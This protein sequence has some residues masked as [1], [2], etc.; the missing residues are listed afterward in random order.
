MR[1]NFRKFKSMLIALLIFSLIM[2]AWLGLADK[3]SAEYTD[4]AMFT[5][6]AAYASAR[7]INALISTFQ[8]AQ[9]S[10]GFA[11]I[12]V[13]E[14]LDPIN[15]LIERFSAVMMWCLGSLALQKLMI[16]AL[17]TKTF[18]VVFTLVG[19][20]VLLGLIFKNTTLDFAKKAFVML[21]AMRFGLFVVLLLNSVI[22]SV[23]LNARIE[24]DKQQ[25]RS[26]QS[27]LAIFESEIPDGIK[28]DIQNAMRRLERMAENKIAADEEVVRLTQKISDDS[29]QLEQLQ[30]LIATSIWPWSSTGLTED[31]TTQAENSI[32]QL[33]VEIQSLETQLETTRQ[34]IESFTQQ[35]ESL[36]EAV[37][38]LEKKEQG[39]SCTWSVS[40]YVPSIGLS[41]IKTF[42]KTFDNTLQSII[43]LL[44]ALLLQSVI[45]PLLFLWLV[46]YGFNSLWRALF[47]E[48]KTNTRMRPQGHLNKAPTTEQ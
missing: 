36:T 46:K 19:A 26:F 13:G 28:N 29:A 47:L 15:D 31:E 8:T 35:T 25:V 2:I 10:V 44:V 24:E 22:S 32:A 33:T 23:F 48:Q 38:C 3:K 1:A 4:A 43:N 45:L 5:T 17:A 12:S 21:V 34:D 41:T 14:L 11:S 6:G 16:A 42:K 20:A 40:D 7:T 39:E 18:Q 30:E 37:A 9:V 27:E